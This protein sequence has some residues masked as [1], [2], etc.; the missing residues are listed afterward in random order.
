LTIN[1]RQGT[2]GLS[3]TDSMLKIFSNSISKY[4]ATEIIY[5]RDGGIKVILP[6]WTEAVTREDE[7]KLCKRQ[8]IRLGIFWLLWQN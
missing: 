5:N 4:I 2:D 6:P 3:F 1:K 7:K 8:T